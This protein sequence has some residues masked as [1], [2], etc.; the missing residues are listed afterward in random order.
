MAQLGRQYVERKRLRFGGRSLVD[1]VVHK[2]PRSGGHSLCMSHARD[3]GR[4]QLVHVL[5]EWPNL[6][7][8]QGMEQD[9]LQGRR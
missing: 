9:T 2:W 8:G 7:T 5:R 3:Q 1:D 4:A 6:E